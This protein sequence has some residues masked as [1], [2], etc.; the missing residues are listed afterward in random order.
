MLLVDVGDA[1]SG[2]GEYA[3]LKADFYAK[4]L[5]YM[6]YSAVGV[7]DMEARFIR[8]SESPKPYGDSVRA[9]CANVVDASSGKL[10]APQP[11]IIEKT[12]SG[13]KVGII[14]VLGDQ[15]VG[16]WLAEKV[17]I[18]V[19]PPAEMLRE[20]LGELR[21][22]S[23]LVIL[24]SHA[25]RERSKSLATEVPG[26][27][28]IL[29]GHSSGTVQE[30]PERIGSTLLMA[31]RSSGQY[32]G[33][34]V[35]DIGADRE[36]TAFTGEYVPMS[37]D[38]EDDSKIVGLLA[39][40]NRDLQ[41]YYAAMRAQLA[42]RYPDQSSRKRGP[43]PF[44]SSLR[45]R[46]CHAKEYHSWVNTDHAKAFESL[47]KSNQTTDPECASCHTTGFKLPGGFTA[48]A[49]TPQF[50]GVQCEVCHGPGVIH[51]RRPAKGYGAVLRSSCAQCH[52][53]TRS[54]EFDYA[55]YRDRITHKTEGDGGTD[56]METGR[57]R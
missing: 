3:R 52:D 7:G 6:G 15:L 37:K 57:P 9:V 10:I 25:G 33:K 51:A 14:S 12:R 49:A 11:Y 22:K 20:H 17:G 2:T 8:E 28:V 36:I 54:P 13:L 43:Q 44:V 16:P 18:R 29:S 53:P 48:E 40:H 35:L 39:Q 26:I 46:D 45:C 32:V 47:R 38:F 5:S 42:R 1:V 55:K 31:T 50:R 19:L 30:N 56:T 27:D 23:D 41:A 24:L 21:A 34:L 4:A